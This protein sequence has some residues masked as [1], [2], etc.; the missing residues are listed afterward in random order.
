M[1]KGAGALEQAAS[2]LKRL[3]TTLS[4]AQELV[5]ELAREVTEAEEAAE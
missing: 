1:L 3:S 4:D 2:A 5:R